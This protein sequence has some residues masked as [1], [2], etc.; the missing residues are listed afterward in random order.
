MITEKMKT[1]IAIE[2]KV[3][4]DYICEENKDD[5]YDY[6]NGLRSLDTEVIDNLRWWNEIVKVVKVG[7]IFIKFKYA[8]TTGDDSPFD[9]GYDLDSLSSIVEVFPHTIQTIVYK[10]NQQSKFM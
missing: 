1:Q 6:L 9:K 10:E 7:N 5:I 2:M 4:V 3:K 8:E